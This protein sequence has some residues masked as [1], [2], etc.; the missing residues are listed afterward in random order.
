MEL[1][2][3]IRES[4]ATVRTRTTLVFHGLPLAAAESLGSI[5][6]EAYLA[7]DLRAG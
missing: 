1:E 6:I 3:V 7:V 2:D 5:G 4:S